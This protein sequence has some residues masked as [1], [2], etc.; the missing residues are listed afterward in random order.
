M[1]GDPTY[2]A[3]QAGRGWLC[4]HA[5][6]TSHHPA[7]S[8]VLLHVCFLPPS[9]PFDPQ[10]LY[11]DGEE[12]FLLL[13]NERVIWRMPASEVG[14]GE[15]DDDG[16]L[17]TDGLAGAGAGGVG[18]GGLSSLDSDL[19]SADIMEVEETDEPTDDDTPPP[20]GGTTGKKKGGVV[21]RTRRRLRT[22]KSR[23]RGGGAGHTQEQG[24]AAAG[25][26]LR[27]R[28]S[29][30]RR[31]GGES[32]AG[33]VM[34]ASFRWAGNVRGYACWWEPKGCVECLLS[35]RSHL[36]TGLASAA[37]SCR[38]TVHAA[39]L[40]ARPCGSLPCPVRLLCRCRAWVLRVTTAVSLAA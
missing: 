6:S 11:Q 34:G 23:V 9:P 24:E 3:A 29:R 2:A 35:V 36:P 39:C 10:V 20:A 18:G 37:R 19:D 14:G 31:A 7:G 1:L 33:G 8:P 16:L 28:K 12:E 38:L 5:S 27:T 32:Q 21:K 4:G 40:P 26:G 30:V 22:R 17:D 13:R 25:V 15:G